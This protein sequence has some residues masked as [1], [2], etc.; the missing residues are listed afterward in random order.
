MFKKC[1]VG[2]VAL[3]SISH[4]SGERWFVELDW[5]ISM[6]N[7]SGSYDLYDASGY[8]VVHT[9]WEGT[10]DM[11]HIELGRMFEIQDSGALLSLSGG[12]TFTPLDS[13]GS[14]N[15]FFGKASLLY[16]TT[17]FNK[18]IYIGPKV[19]AI[20]P[21]NSYEHDKDLGVDARKVEYD[22]NTAFAFGAEAVWGSGDWQMV[23]GVE[24]LTSAKY[25]GRYS[26]NNGYADAKMDLNGLYFNIGIRYNF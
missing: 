22:T 14:N 2:L 18:D 12:T 8:K 17:V 4:A 5:Q 11:L 25:E 23:T 9:G 7:T 6:P 10:Y 20:L 21:F 16:P 13:T 3:V 24:Y 1:M 19:K 15:A 26:D